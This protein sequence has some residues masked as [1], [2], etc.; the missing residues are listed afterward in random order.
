M[1]LFHNC[2]GSVHLWVSSPLGQDGQTFRLLDSAGPP[3]F[4]ISN[5]PNIN[6]P[7]PPPPKK[8]TQKRSQYSLQKYTQ[9][10]Y[11]VI[12]RVTNSDN[13]SPLLTTIKHYIPLFFTLW[14][15]TSNLVSRLF[16]NV[17]GSRAW[18]GQGIPDSAAAHG[19]VGLSNYQEILTMNNYHNWASI[20]Y[21]EIWLWV[22][23]VFVEYLYQ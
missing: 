1:T 15:T 21:N 5:D 19:P 11:G 3:G 14:S 8:K 9:S 20:S 22:S 2:S 23:I 12:F 10:V 6:T 13:K 7:P 17:T 4:W 16:V 18:C